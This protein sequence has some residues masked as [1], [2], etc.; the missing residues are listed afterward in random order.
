MSERITRYRAKWISL[1]KRQNGDL[2]LA[3]DVYAAIVSRYTADDRHYHNFA[4]IVGMLDLL[5]AMA[6]VPENRTA[7]RLAIWFHDVIYE[8]G[9]GLDN[10]RASA[11]FATE[12]LT[13]LKFDG[14]LIQRVSELIIDT[15]HA[16]RPATHDG[17]LLADLDLSQIGGSAEQ[18][19]RD[20]AD[21]R[22]E[23]ATVPDDL[24]WRG[25]RQVLQS[26]LNRERIY[27]TEPFFARFEA[28]ARNNLRSAI[29][30]INARYPG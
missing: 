18:F 24:F 21:I 1:V 28:N 3:D 29:Q 19:Q 13:A 23:Y 26:F 30:A 10:E 22:R 7:L 8:V 20:S 6:V 9:S 16:A 5:D 4:H 17:R 12:Q 14:V 11:D 15:K 2:S 27:Y 25:R